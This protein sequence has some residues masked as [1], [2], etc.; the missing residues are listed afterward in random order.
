MGTFNPETPPPLLV[1]EAS[2]SSAIT[3]PQKG[4]GWFTVKMY[5]IMKWELLL[6]N[7]SKNFNIKINMEI[8]MKNLK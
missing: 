6:L 4:V 1:T 3:G 8:F 2:D 7:L 5:Q